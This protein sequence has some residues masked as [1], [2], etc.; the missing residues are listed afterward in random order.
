MQKFALH[1]CL[2]LVIITGLLFPVSCKAYSVLTHEAIVDASWEKSI[3]PL[4][5]SKYPG[6]TEA[7]FKEAH[8]YAYGGAILDDMGYYPFGSVF[9]RTSFTT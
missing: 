6:S 7:Q 9:F 5:K 8:A 1:I 4:L 2:L 3:L